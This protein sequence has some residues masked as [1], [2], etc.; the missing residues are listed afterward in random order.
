VKRFFERRW[1]LV[2][3]GLAIGSV[4]FLLLFVTL[5]RDY[6]EY[7]FFPREKVADGYSYPELRYTAFDLVLI[8]W[9]LD[10]LVASVMSIRGA[11]SSPDIS[12][13]TH[14]TL[15]LYLALFAVLLLGGMLMMVARS[16]GY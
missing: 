2:P 1:F 12:Q 4:S 11:S 15:V 13:W 10:G 7:W 8:L 6:Y 3:L 16:R 9:C 14:R 5:Q